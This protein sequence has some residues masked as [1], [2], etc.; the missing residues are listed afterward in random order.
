MDSSLWIRLE[1][2]D[3]ESGEVIGSLAMEID[4]DSNSGIIHLDGLHGTDD[5]VTGEE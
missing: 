5:P 1:F 4:Q 3:E 2:L